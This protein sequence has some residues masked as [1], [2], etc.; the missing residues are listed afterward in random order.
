[1]SDKPLESVFSVHI[2]FVII[3]SFD[4]HRATACNAKHGI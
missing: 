3:V 4:F 1:M 2:N